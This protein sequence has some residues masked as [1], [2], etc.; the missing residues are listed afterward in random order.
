MPN[1]P[2]EPFISGVVLHKSEQKAKVP[3]DLD[4]PEDRDQTAS[5]KANTLFGQPM[6]D[7][8]FKEA[9]S[10]LADFF[11]LLRKWAYEEDSKC[12]EE[13]PPESD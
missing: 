4:I 2:S 12:C 10:N 7:Q 1:S 11:R 6:N 3:V 5:S 13:S 8:E 9:V